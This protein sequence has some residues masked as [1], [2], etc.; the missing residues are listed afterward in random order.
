MFCVLVDGSNEDMQ[1]FRNFE[2]TVKMDIL[3]DVF[4]IVYVLH[5]IVCKIYVSND[6][7]KK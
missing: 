6:N 1:I 3:Y 4:S 2:Y 5:Y 7:L